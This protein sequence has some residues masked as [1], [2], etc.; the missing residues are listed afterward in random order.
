MPQKLFFLVYAA[1]AYVAGSASIAYIIGFLADFLVPKSIVDGPATPIG[2]AIIIDAGLVLLF[3]LHHSVTARAS[4][5]RWWTKIV[6]APIERAT[7]LFMTAAM[8]ALLVV[9][10]RPIPVE[11]WSVDNPALSGAI[12]AAYGCVW[13]MMVS[14]T[15]HFGHFSFFGLTQ[16]WN[17]LQ[18]RQ[19]T[20]SGMTERFL[21]A[22]V[23][24]PISIGWMMAPWL[25]PNLTL[26]HVVFAG[27]TMVYI[28]AA[29]PFEEQD[30]IDEIGDDYRDYRK[31]TP[32]FFP[33]LFSKKPAIRARQ[34]VNG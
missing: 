34:R 28:L 30:L 11:L 10:W 1:F 6:P 31:R 24:H 16:V 4:F 9:L 32:A 19:P 23:R 33:R 12:Y 18:N 25:T 17:H 13:I 3:G 22:L 2:E 20:S 26:G 14:A 29:T 8:T 21:Y 5:K 27:A 7:Y 15:F